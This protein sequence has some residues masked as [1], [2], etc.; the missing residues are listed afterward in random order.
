MVCSAFRFS[1]WR[2]ISEGI[3]DP[4]HFALEGAVLALASCSS[5]PLSAY[6]KWHSFQ[7]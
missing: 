5:P 3:K 6:C 1:I 4:S 2:P 7:E